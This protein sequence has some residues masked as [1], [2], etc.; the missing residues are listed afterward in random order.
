[1]RIEFAGLGLAIALLMPATAQAAC[2]V[3]QRIELAKAGYDKSEVERL[4]S[5][6]VSAPPAAIPQA[7]LATGPQAAADPLAV[8]RSAT[9]DVGTKGG[10]KVMFPP[11][12]Q[13]QFLGD[14]VRVHEKR[15]IGGRE[16]KDIP[17]SAFSSVS[18]KGHR[19]YS[20][21]RNGIVTAHIAISAIMDG[22]EVMCFVMLVRR[23]DI[24]AGGFDAFVAE[25]QREYEGVQAALKALGVPVTG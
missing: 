9:Y 8:L 4:C 6:E 2:S 14:R 18:E 21:L 24:E 16:P 10:A 15:L 13:C 19:F 11:E 17:L 20:K 7:P 3:E 23:R 5:Q 1:M 22:D 25:K 12:A